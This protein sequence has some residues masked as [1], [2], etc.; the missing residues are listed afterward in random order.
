[1]EKC[2]CITTPSEF[3]KKII[4]KYGVKKKIFVISNG[5]DLSEFNQKKIS[6]KNSI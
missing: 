6:E 2:N 3:S 1:L 4:E 5:V